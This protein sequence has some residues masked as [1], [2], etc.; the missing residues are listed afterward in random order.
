MKRL[1]IVHRFPVAR[2]G[3]IKLIEEH[4][5]EVLVAEAGTESDA[6]ERVR[7]A[8]WDLV[9]MGPLRHG[10]GSTFRIYLPVKLE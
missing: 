9:V 8:N 6:L 2:Y 10:Q 7:A 3:L 1:L 4:L 5:H